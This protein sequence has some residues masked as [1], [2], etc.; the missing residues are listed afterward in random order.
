MIPMQHRPLQWD[1]AI[2]IMAASALFWLGMAI[3]PDPLGP[4]VYGHMAQNVE[5]EAW[6]AGFL[7]ASLMVLYGCHINGRWRW[8]PVLRIAGYVIL[9]VL[10]LLLTYSSFSAPSG[11][12]IWSWTLPCFVWPCV[13]FLRLNII[14]A[15][16]R[17]RGR[18]GC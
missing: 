9:T 8:S 5:A 7:G 6:A 11:V 14:D 18:D 16:R 10:F 4:S 1:F 17:W 3:T 2:R 13:R 12:V 15:G